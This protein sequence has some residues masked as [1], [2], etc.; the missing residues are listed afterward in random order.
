MKPTVFLHGRIKPSIFGIAILLFSAADMFGAGTVT[1]PDEAKLR[2]ALVGGGLVTFDCDGTI[3]LAN[4]LVITN[5]TTLDAS[6]HSIERSGGDAVRLLTANSLITLSLV[7]LTVA[8]GLAAGTNG[9]PGQNGGDAAGG[10][11]WLN[12]ARLIALNCQFRSNAAK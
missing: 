1:V 7:N 3:A 11:V 6:G 12:G 9:P 2:A 5:H 8:N 4:T 10:G